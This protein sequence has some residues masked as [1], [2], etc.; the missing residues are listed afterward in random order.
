MRSRRAYTSVLSIAGS[1]CSGGA[2]IQAD[3]KTISANSGYAASVITALTAQNTQGVQGI[4]PIP[5]DFIEQ[6]CESVFTDIH[7]DAVKIG[8]LYSAEL[9]QSLAKIFKK[10][11][12]K[13]IVLDPVMVSTSGDLLIENNAIDTLKNTLFP[14]ATLIT[15]NIAEAEKISG[16]TIKSKDDMK[17]IAKK[18]AQHYKTNILL[19]GGHFYD[20]SADDLLYQFDGQIEWFCAKK[21]DTA[22][23]HGTGCTLSSAIATYLAR[24]CTL[25]DAIKQAKH[26]LHQALLNGKDYQ[27]GHGHGPVN[28]F[29][30]EVTLLPDSI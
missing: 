16:L 21:I 15:P 24:R 13:N 28:H 12:V 9:M 18:L 6:Q 7:I 29:Q 19:K 11:N 4:Y 27:L 22:N 1:D 8:M 10:H 14:I 5:V 23:T 3:I 25:P 26:Y 20:Q 30:D 2:G 17:T